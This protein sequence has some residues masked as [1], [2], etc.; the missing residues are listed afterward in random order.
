MKKTIISTMTG[1]LLSMSAIAQFQLPPSSLNAPPDARQYLPY[2]STVPAMVVTLANGTTYDNRTDRKRVAHFWKTYAHR[3][4]P[5]LLS[6]VANY[7]SDFVST[8]RNLPSNWTG[9]VAGCVAGKI[10][11][12][13]QEA[14]IRQV[15]W[16]RAMVGLVPG[17]NGSEEDRLSAQLAAL[18]MKS[19]NNVGLGLTH[20]PGPAYPCYS[21][22]A[23]AAA[24]R[25]NLSTTNGP[26]QLGP[27]SIDAY[28][29]DIGPG[30][31]G[32]GHRNIEFLAGKRTFSYGEVAQ[33]DQLPNPP[34][35]GGS[36]ALLRGNVSLTINQTNDAGS[37]GPAEILWPNPGYVPIDVFPRISGRWSMSCWDCDFTGATVSV[38]RNGVDTGVTIEKSQNNIS[39]QGMVVWRVTGVDYL[40]F[41]P[42]SYT[43]FVQDDVF[44]VTVSYTRNGNVATRSYRTTVF[45]PEL[46]HD[47]APTFDITDMWWNANES[48]W[49]LKLVQGVDGNV[50]GTV[51][52]YDEVGNPRWITMQGKW[53][54]QS[55]FTGNLYGARG[56]NFAAMQFDPSAVQISQVG[57]GTLTFS[58]DTQS[59][60]FDFS[61][62]SQAGSKQ[63]VRFAN[64]PEGYRDGTNYRGMWWNANESGWGLTMQHYFNSLF[65]A[66]FTYNPDGSPLWVTLQ[67][68]WR[69]A[70]TYEGKFYATEQAPWN[71]ALFD[72]G[73][74][75]I[76][77]A[78][79]GKLTFTEFNRATF[80]YTLNGVSGKKQ[81]EKFE[82]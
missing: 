47:F 27:G 70:I 34:A 32:V 52:F 53:T 16:Y 3:S 19:G 77:E 58:P 79:V 29:D 46:E 80:E 49:G 35:V 17:K 54:A 75:K 13:I 11:T 67:G 14:T 62:G 50:F 55:L 21:V 23:N 60:R 33:I 72:P 82:F 4:V 12:G 15:N 40:S 39:G 28:M 10:D 41:A 48:G 57:T 56:G 18:V 42:R 63:L 66:W 76:R 68:T 31:E 1:A 78:G 9:N 25:S 24:T 43:P 51:F 74:T 73:A 37:A 7:G 20:N 36:Y 26:D 22:E 81:I 6:E 64:I 69:D 65:V 30:N 5:V 44:D 61:M 45:N 38:K 2:G 71:P 59:L 8:A